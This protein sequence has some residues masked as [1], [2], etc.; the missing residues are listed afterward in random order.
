MGG[1]QAMKNG[2]GIT[3]SHL[4][5]KWIFDKARVKADIDTFR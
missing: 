4:K 3:E 5:C 1:G 2:Y